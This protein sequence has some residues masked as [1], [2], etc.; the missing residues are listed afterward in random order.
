MK[1]IVVKIYIKEEYIEQ[2]KE[3]TLYNSQNSRKELG[4]L[5]FDLTQSIDNPTVFFLY[6]LYTSDEAIEHHR[7]TDH[8]K[9]WRDTVADM[10]SQP[11]E[12]AKAEVINE[13]QI[14]SVDGKNIAY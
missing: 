6:E 5:C 9:K 12:S 10:M 1:S 4:N 3:I 14:T 11:R 2:F 13:K 8:Y 7:N